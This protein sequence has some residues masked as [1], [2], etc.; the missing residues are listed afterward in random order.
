[1]RPVAQDPLPSPALQGGSSLG[2]Q[3]EQ[4]SIVAVW[5]SRT[6]ENHRKVSQCGDGFMLQPWN[7]LQQLNDEMVLN[8]PAWEATVRCEEQSHETVY[9][10][11]T[12]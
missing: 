3:R 10:R 7:T 2:S 4:E 8:V 1:M 12:Q 5:K 9:A 6:T 11:Y